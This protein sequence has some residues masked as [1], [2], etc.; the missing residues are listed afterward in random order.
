MVPSLPDAMLRSLAMVSTPGRTSERRVRS[1][2]HSRNWDV[3]PPRHSVPRGL[4][5]MVDLGGFYCNQTSRQERLQAGRARLRGA[6]QWCRLCLLWRSICSFPWL[7]GGPMQ[8]LFSESCWLQHRPMAWCCHQ[9][10][11]MQAIRGE[12]YGSQ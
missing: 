5:P 4:L 12:R 10:T 3:R 1:R 9:L 2:Q 6:L 7:T 11:S 8:L